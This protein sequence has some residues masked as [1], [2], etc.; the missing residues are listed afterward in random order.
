MITLQYNPNCNPIGKVTIK[1]KSN[2]RKLNG[3]T[4]DVVEYVPQQRVTCLVPNDWG[5]GFFKAD[6]SPNECKL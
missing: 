4:L 3:K 2:Y 1:T 6:F 5:T